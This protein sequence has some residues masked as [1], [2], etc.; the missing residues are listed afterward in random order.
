[1]RT[2]PAVISMIKDAALTI[3]PDAYVTFSS[4]KQNEKMY[5]MQERNKVKSEF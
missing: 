1:M 5:K 2:E 4:L 3:L